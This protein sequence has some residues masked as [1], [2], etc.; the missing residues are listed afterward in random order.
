M[1]TLMTGVLGV[2]T[3]CLV[4]AGCSKKENNAA[5]TGAASGAMAAPPAGSSA[6]A[7][8]S[9]SGATAAPATLTD[10]NIVYILDQ[11]NAAD[12]ARGTLAATKGTSADVRRFGK[13]MAGEHHELRMQGKQ[14]AKKLG[15]TPQAP[16][17]DQSEAQAAAEM[18][19]LKAMPKGKA[20]DKAYIDYEVNYHQAVINTATAALGQAQNQQL[21]DLIKKAAP[22]LQRHL[23]MAQDIQ[24]KLGS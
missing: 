1:R 10:A 20:W 18:D 3:A 17:G 6:T 13:M 5:D 9:A 24:K 2:A 16:A 23:Q 15:V 21:K 11:A 14:L 4:V 8:A 12:S 19:S 7:G 22:I